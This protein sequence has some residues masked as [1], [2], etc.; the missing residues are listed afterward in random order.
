MPPLTRTLIFDLPAPIG[1]VTVHHDPDWSGN[2]EIR[3]AV[4]AGVQGKTAERLVTLPGAIAVE[5]ARAVALE[6][7]GR[8]VAD[9]IDRFRAGEAA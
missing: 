6:E 2:A 8:M 7:V 9:A 1:R 5:L 4:P 3:Y